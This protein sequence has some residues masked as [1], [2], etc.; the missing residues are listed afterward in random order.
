MIHVYMAAVFPEE[1]PAFFSMITG[2]VHELYAYS[3]PFKWWSEEKAKR[4]ALRARREAALAA[5][6]SVA[7]PEAKGPDKAPSPGAGKA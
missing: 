1:K 6:P 7:A 3:H 2:S 4:L 5:A